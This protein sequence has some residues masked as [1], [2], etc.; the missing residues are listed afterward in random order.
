MDQFVE[1]V[2][3]HPS[4]FPLVLFGGEG[5]VEVLHSRVKFAANKGKYSHG[6][7]ALGTRVTVEETVEPTSE[8]A[9]F[10]LWPWRSRMKRIYRVWLS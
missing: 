1:V 6:L 3:V 4:S 10:R 9:Y 8:H 7:G 2:E 5:T